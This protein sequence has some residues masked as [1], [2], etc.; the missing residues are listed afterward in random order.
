MDRSVVAN[1]LS[2]DLST[3][4]S[5]QNEETGPS[6]GPKVHESH[7]AGTDDLSTTP[8]VTFSDILAH[9][10]TIRRK[11]V[12]SGDPFCGKSSLCS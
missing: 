4:F 3:L 2:T 11:L 6:S 7:G 10:D 8:A 5:F 12:T 9:R 1:D